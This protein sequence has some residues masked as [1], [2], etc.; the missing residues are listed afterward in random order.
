MAA[1][2]THKSP[3]PPPQDSTG[4]L[5]WIEQGIETVLIL[6]ITVTP[7]LF[8]PLSRELFE[9]PKMVWV[10]L[11]AIIGLALLLAKSTMQSKMEV[12]IHPLQKPLLI[13][14]L[15]F[16]VSTILSLS[17]YTSIMGY[18]SRFHGG[19]ASLG[20]YL[21]IFYLALDYLQPS[22][23]RAARIAKLL[24][25]WVASSVVVSVW[26][27]AEHFGYSPSCWL[28]RGELNA[29]CWVQDVQARVF[30]TFGQPNWLATYFI[31]SIPL[32]LALLLSGAK[33]FSRIMAWLGATLGYAAF[34]YTYSRSGWVGL[35]VAGIVLLPWFWRV[36]YRQVWPWLGSAI[37][38]CGLVSLSTIQMAEQRTA[39][40]LES[41]NFDSSTGQIRLLVW[42]GSLETFIQYPIFGSGPETFPYSFLQHRPAELNQ[43]TEWN[44]LYNKAHN[45]ALQYAATTGLV[46]L[47]AW[48]FIY[49]YLLYFSW[50]QGIISFRPSQLSADKMVPASLLS[51]IL[52]VFVAQLLGFSVVVTSLYFWL[53]LAI[54]LAPSTKVKLVKLQTNW[55]P[56]VSFAGGLL[57]IG[58]LL[59][60]GSYYF[61][62]IVANQ[63]SAG[64]RNNPWRS[65][66]QLELATKLNPFEST[67]WQQL[68]LANAYISQL[69]TDTGTQSDYAI[70]ADHA[71]QT[72][73]E[74]NPHHIL[75]LKGITSVYLQ[76]GSVDPKY[77]D[78][79][80]RFARM[81]VDL[82]ANDANAQKTLAQLYLQTNQ[83]ENALTAYN[84]VIS[85]RPRS[86]DS[87]L[88]RAQYYQ[89]ANQ[90]ELAFQDLKLAQTLDPNNPEVVDR[91][92]QFQNEH[93][94]LTF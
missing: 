44:F 50:R 18:Y 17:V 77:T 25:S 52:G 41:G 68:A 70:A 78:L 35:A 22:A 75:N 62:E 20:S 33:K 34:W 94:N 45:E 36:N 15:V 11:L 87:Y 60:L 56:I 42:Q 85:L 30:A 58:A 66:Q 5:R 83:H 26:A 86:A 1:T 24:W 4:K 57:L 27:I 92:Q 16:I 74:I 67:Y 84:N 46:G 49:F 8:S 14:V 47:I 59:S 63:A 29:A 76:L 73:Y 71:A 28:L 79:A 21:V 55:K 10:Y 80:I 13:Y 7:L 32:S 6:A 39:T 61:A 43:T 9:F 3:S 12:P 91:L 31:T 89:Q 82:D 90:S 64:L 23:E 51:G 2:S 69:G 54:I 53:A 72:A 19:L 48:L 38:V 88:G 40:A 81:A 65:E 93:P 37:V